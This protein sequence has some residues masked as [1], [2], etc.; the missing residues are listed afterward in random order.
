M[1]LIADGDELV[2]LPMGGN[3]GLPKSLL[4]LSNTLLRCRFLPT[5]SD[6]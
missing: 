5:P 4:S 1:Q 2:I 6:I 3:N